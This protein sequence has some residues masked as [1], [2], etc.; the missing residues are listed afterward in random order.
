MRMV[1]STVGWT[2]ALAAT[3]LAVG[4]LHGQYSTK[5][6]GTLRWGSGRVDVPSA[7]VLPHMAIVGTFSGFL[8]DIDENPV[9]NGQGRV[10]GSSGPLERWYSDATLGFGLLDRIEVGAVVHALDD[11]GS[12]NLIGGFGR[13]ALLRPAPDRSGIGLAAGVRASTN[14]KYRDDLVYAANRLGIPD[15]NFRQS[16]GPGSEQIRTYYTFYGV[17]SAFLQG[18]Q[19]DVFPDHDF[20]FTLG[21]EDGQFQDGESLSW[22]SFTSA[23]GLFGGGTLHMALTE[24]TLLNVSRDFN[25]FDVNLGAQLDLNGIRLGVH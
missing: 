6:P 7:S 21:W 5:V 25:G 23:K 11:K 14:P 3:L 18:F 17:A 9:I 24:K 20:T 1:R 4:P 15:S 10:V 2:A 22:Y 8:V 16:Y 19:S 12:G 13:I